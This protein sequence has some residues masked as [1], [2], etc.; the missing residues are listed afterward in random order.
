[1]S[2]IKA[3][4]LGKPE[5]GGLKKLDLHDV[6]AEARQVVADARM[7][8]ERILAAARREAEGIKQREAEVGRR[9]GYE[10]GMEEGRQA[11]REQA[12]VEA[13]QQFEQQ[14]KGLIESCQRI[15]TEINKDRVQWKAMA[16]QDLVELAMA[17]GRRVA[18]SVGER[19][20]EVVLANLD[21]AIQL[22]GTRSEVTIAVSPA[23]AEAAQTFAQSLMEMREHWDNIRVIEEPD[24]TPGGCR[25]HWSSGAVDGSLEAQLDRIENALRNSVQGGR[26][27]GE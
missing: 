10:K 7:E 27:K 19:D 20:R 23:D 6:M 9:E 2:V 18:R 15:I 14:Q 13:K 5:S 21:E 16:R 11:G 4:Q 22:A 26:E 17:V 1:M 8:A 3:G 12:L 24:I 25:V